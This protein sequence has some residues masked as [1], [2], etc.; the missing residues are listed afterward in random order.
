MTTV[1]NVAIELSKNEAPSNEARDP[2]PSALAC[3]KISGSEIPQHSLSILD[4]D[5]LSFG[6]KF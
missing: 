6:F 3:A 1:A 4:R 2:P 5:V